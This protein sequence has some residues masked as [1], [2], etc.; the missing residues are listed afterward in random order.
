[1]MAGDE[2]LSKYSDDELR[3]SANRYRHIA[4]RDDRTEQE[5]AAAQRNLDRVEA[6]QKRRK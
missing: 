3:Q 5:K 4:G 6:E 1:M 2:E